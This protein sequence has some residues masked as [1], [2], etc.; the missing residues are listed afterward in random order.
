V[1]NKQEKE[2]KHKLGERELNG[3]NVK[4]G[5]QMQE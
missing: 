1:E 5:E 3:K 2:R 4:W